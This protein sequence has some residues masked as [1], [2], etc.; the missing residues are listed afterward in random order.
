MIS[1]CRYFIWLTWRRLVHRPIIS[2]LIILVVI[3][4]GA[5]LIVMAFEKVGFGNAMMEIFPAFLGE[6][7][8][9]ESPFLAVQI[10]MVVG[11]LV[12]I[13]FIAVVTAKITS[14]LIEFIRRGGSMAKKVNFSGHTLICGWNFQGERIVDELL[15]ADQK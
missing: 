9:I 4:L 13:S 2:I 1:R 10:S 8:I 14:L 11:M 7:G 5:T 12:S 15:S 6:L 3:Y